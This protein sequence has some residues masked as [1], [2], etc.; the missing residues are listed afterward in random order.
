MFGSGARGQRAE[1]QAHAGGRV[2]TQRIARQQ[3]VEQRSGARRIA[4]RHSQPR[5]VE[6]PSLPCRGEGV[7]RA[8][9]ITGEQQR[10][11]PRY[12]HLAHGG[13]RQVGEQLSRGRRI[14][15]DPGLTHPQ[16]RVDA[17]ELAS[18]A[19]G[20]KRGRGAIGLTGSV[21]GEGRAHRE[22]RHTRAGR[23]RPGHLKVRRGVGVSPGAVLGLRQHG[24]RL[25]VEIV[26][27]PRLPR[28]QLPGVL[29]AAGVDFRLGAF[30]DQE[31]VGIG[32]ATRRGE[33]RLGRVPGTAR[34]AQRISAKRRGVFRRG[35]ILAPAPPRRRQHQVPRQR[36]EPKGASFH[37][38]ACLKR[39]R[40]R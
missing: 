14:A 2:I 11:R 3:G 32:I 24:E 15:R 26:E 34:Q 25:P 17:R 18:R 28:Q 21:E 36:R 12:W 6:R 29:V 4:P 31:C 38:P 39:A 8:G 16:P 37:L 40:T 1:C 5:R 22:H 10:A 30:D 20:G 33:Q 35:D 19:G 23:T 9:R 7:D 13:R 27:Q